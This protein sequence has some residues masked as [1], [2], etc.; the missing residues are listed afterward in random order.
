MGKLAVRDLKTGNIMYFP[1]NPKI[2]WIKIIVV[3]I[4]IAFLIT[5]ILINNL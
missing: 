3:I 5:K 2:E 1:D 4:M